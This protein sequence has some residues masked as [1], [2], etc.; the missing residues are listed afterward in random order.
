[1]NMLFADGSVQFHLK[2][3]AQRIIADNKRKDTDR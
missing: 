1:M 3:E 2:S